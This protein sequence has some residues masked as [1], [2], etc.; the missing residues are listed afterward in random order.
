MYERIRVPLSIM[1]AIDSKPSENSI[2]SNAVGID[3]NVLKTLLESSPF[4][5]GVYR[6]GSK[7]SVCAIPPAIHKRITESAVL[8]I[9]PEQE[10]NNAERGEPA[11]KAAKAPTPAVRKKSLLL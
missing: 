6:F 9:L 5:Y 11:A 3:L 2:P 8:V 4:S 1:A 7:V 10:D